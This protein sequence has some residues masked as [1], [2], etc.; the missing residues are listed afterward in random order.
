MLVKVGWDAARLGGP[1]NLSV[2]SNLSIMTFSY[3]KQLLPPNPESLIINM[4]IHIHPH[5]L[6]SFHQHLSPLQQ[7][8]TTD[9]DSRAHNTPDADNLPAGRRSR[10][11][12]CRDGGGGLARALGRGRG[13]GDLGRGGRLCRAG[14]LCALRARRPFAGRDVRGRTGERNLGGRHGGAR[15]VADA[16]DVGGGE[17]GVGHAQCRVAAGVGG[18]RVREDV[19]TRGAQAGRLVAELE[20]VVAA[21]VWGK[22]FVRREI[23]E[24]VVV[25]GEAYCCLCRLSTAAC[26]I[27]CNHLR[28]IRTASR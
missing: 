24:A 17:G 14:C 27:C 26:L 5:P 8:R 19:G 6:V 20:G 10:G 22:G 28:A 21:P 3:R 9:S 13:R 11:R 18:E 16:L 15:G 4:L 7:E 12:L 25:V 2:I 23:E 1:S